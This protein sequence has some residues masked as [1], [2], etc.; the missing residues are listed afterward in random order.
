MGLILKKV[1]LEDYTD[2]KVLYSKLVRNN[3][4][5]TIETHHLESGKHL[6][7]FLYRN[8]PRIKEFIDIRDKKNHL[9]EQITQIETNPAQMRL[10]INDTSFMIAASNNST[11]KITEYNFN[12]NLADFAKGKV[13][14]L[15]D[16]TFEEE[17]DNNKLVSEL[18]SFN[19]MEDKNEGTSN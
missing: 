16:I 6:Q 4:D 8:H 11:I 18:R 9:T 1:V 17:V 12:Q 15:I 3:L 5:F 2:K 19:N 14:I 10:A 13:A 7:I